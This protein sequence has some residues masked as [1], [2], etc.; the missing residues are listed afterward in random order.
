[1]FIAYFDGG[2]RVFDI[3][4]PYHPKN[5]AYFIPNVTDNTIPTTV[6]INGVN[7][8][9]LDVS[10]DNLE[11]DDRGYIYDVDRVGGGADIL[12]LTGC[13]KEIVDNNGDDHERSCRDDDDDH[14]DHDH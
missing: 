12:Q 2:A 11:V 7:Q 8:N 5:V 14:S 4:D 6:K 1:M 13:A 10:S 9:F 3:R